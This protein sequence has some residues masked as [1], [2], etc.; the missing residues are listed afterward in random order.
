MQDLLTIGMDFP[1]LG[2]I[3]IEGD[4]PVPGFDWLFVVLEE[5]L[6]TSFDILA[7]SKEDVVEEIDLSEYIIY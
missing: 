1:K 2:M 7:Y 3:K 5:Q 6:Y 4:D